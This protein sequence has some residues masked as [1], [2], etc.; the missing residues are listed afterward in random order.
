MLDSR[1]PLS[2]ASP[3]TTVASVTLYPRSRWT[4]LSI[5]A[6]LCFVLF[7]LAVIVASIIHPKIPPSLVATIVALPAAAA[8]LGAAARSGPH[9][10]PARGSSLAM[11]LGIPAAA[12][13]LMI[14]LILPSLCRSSETANRV[15]CAS[16]LRQIAN[17]M[18]SYADAHGGHFPSTLE[19]LAR[20][21]D[22]SPAAFV[23][24]SSNDVPANITKAADWGEAFQSGS[25]ESSYV[26]LAGGLSKSAVTP[27]SILA[28]EQPGNHLDEGMN[29]LFGDFHV[30]WFPKAAANQ[31]IA[32]QTHL[33][34]P[35]THSASSTEN[36]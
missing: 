12:I 33:A 8:V 11:K 34:S 18:S 22:L 19:T 21:S 23:C 10:P 20:D 17:A 29:I 32:E 35:A 24:P 16:N 25:H 28:Y 15:K 13:V 14:L 31:I 30:E 2:Y 27:E 7:V 3:S 1:E 6:V 9:G 36:P 26:Y 4:A 5:A